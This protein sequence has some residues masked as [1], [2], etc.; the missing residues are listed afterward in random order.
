MLEMCLFTSNVWYSA[1]FFKP[2][3]VSAQQYD[4]SFTILYV[5]LCAMSK[6]RVCKDCP[7]RAQKQE[8]RKIHELF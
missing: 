8:K 3:S 2:K 7:T 6:R 1:A 5:Y 4:P